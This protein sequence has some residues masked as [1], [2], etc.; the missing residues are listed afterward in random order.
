MRHLP[1][2]LVLGTTGHQH[3]DG[4]WPDQ[5]D[6]CGVLVWIDALGQELTAAHPGRVRVMCHPCDRAT[7]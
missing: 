2:A 7:R 4:R 1:V 6:R 5:C 3:E